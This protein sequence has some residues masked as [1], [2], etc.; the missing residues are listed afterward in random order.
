MRYKVPFQLLSA[1]FNHFRR[2]GQGRREC[3]A[4]WTSHWYA[5]ETIAEVFHPSHIANAE[6]FSLDTGWSHDFWIHLATA[7]KG[8]RV[9]VHTHQNRAF[10]SPSDDAFPIVHT[11]GFLSL[12]I[13][14]FAMGMIGFDGAYLTE[15]GA[16]SSW[17]EV[18][19]E[20][21]FEII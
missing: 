16:D 21:H 20:E 19:C 10:H 13:P 3:Q 6:S 18:P 15:I 9:Q 4:L 14:N 8:I 11:P 17:R 12:V 5:P 2:C 7:D 1:T